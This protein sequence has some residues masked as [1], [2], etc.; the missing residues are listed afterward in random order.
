MENSQEILKNLEKNSAQQ[1]LF[2]KI[3]CTLCALMVICT[4]VLMF[5]ITGAVSQLTELA[6]PLQEL[7]AQVQALAAE[8]DMVMA[9][10]GTVAE[11]LAAADLG[12]IVE[13]VNSLASE[14]QSAVA[15][16]MKKLDAIDIDML[17]QAIR[18][19]ADVVEPLA[20]IT[21]IW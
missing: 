3:L 4:L 13:N 15:G 17:N 11:S 14:S 7:T 8:A 12:S 2:T 6:A 5:S 16:A 9:D 18:D 21:R 1:L 10:L 19:L 20:K